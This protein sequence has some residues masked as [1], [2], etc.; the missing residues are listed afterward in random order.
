MGTESSSDLLEIS[1]LQGA[2]RIKDHAEAVVSDDDFAKRAERWP[3]STPDTK[4]AYLIRQLFDGEPL[5]AS[6]I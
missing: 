2:F 1:H 5:Y 4:E 6:T 3:D